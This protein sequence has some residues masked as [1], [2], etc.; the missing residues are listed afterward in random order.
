MTDDHKHGDISDRAKFDL[1]R[2]AQCWEDAD[3][4][5]E[6]VGDIEGKTCLSIASAGDT[7]LALLTKNPEK[8]IAIDLSLAQIYCL[9]AR[10]AAFQTL[11]HSELLELI[12]SRPSTR[13]GALLAQCYPKMS[14][15]CQ[16]FWKTQLV[17]VHKYGLGGAGKFEKFFQT[18]RN[19][20]LPILNFRSDYGSDDDRRSSQ[21]FTRRTKE[22]RQSWYEH[23]WNTF[24]WRLTLKTVFSKFI[25]G[26]FGR[27]PEFFEYA[28]GS[29]S[30]HVS[31]RVRHAMVDLDPCENPYLQWIM[32]GQHPF[33]LPTYLRLEHFETIR[34]NLHRLE[35]RTQSIEDFSKDRVKFDAFNL[36]NLFEYLSP[37]D[38]EYLYGNLLNISAPKARLVYWN[39][40]VPRSRPERYKDYATPLSDL[41]TKLYA[42]DKAFF[43]SNFHVD[44]VR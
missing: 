3:L 41:S 43:Y 27:D 19:Y 28:Q 17:K 44:E 8:V 1:V 15:E 36:S 22:Q 26:R 10:V 16:A 21:L 33:A 29:L 23:V 7:S 31:N 18:F 12:G 24:R 30:Q 11:T 39:M 2:Y 34:D 13:R 42:K 35:W 38:F 6:G 9:E 25:V 32:T 37:D 5:L 4:L 14:P 40:M 20:L